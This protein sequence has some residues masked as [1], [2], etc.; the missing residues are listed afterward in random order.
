MKEGEG[1]R[2]LRSRWFLAVALAVVLTVGAC[3]PGGG[4]YR[5][6]QPPASSAPLIDY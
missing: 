3:T 4:G 2:G 5:S 1:M 6:A